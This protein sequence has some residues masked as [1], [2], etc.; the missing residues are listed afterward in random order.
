VSADAFPSPESLLRFLRAC[1]REGVAFK[2]TAGLHHP[3]Y[4]THRLTYQANSESAP[5]FGYLNVFLATAF[6]RDGIDDASALALL[7]ESDPSSIRFADDG[8]AWRDRRVTREVLET[9]RR[10][11]LRGFGSCSFREPIDEL[12]ALHLDR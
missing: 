9:V 2:A 5:M 1:A 4:A 6:I 11:A 3:L 10:R 8:V 12:A 7:V